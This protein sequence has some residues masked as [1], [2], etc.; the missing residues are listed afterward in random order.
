M[1]SKSATMTDDEVRQY[2]E[3]VAALVAACVQR[4][5]YYSLPDEAPPDA[6][7]TAREAGGHEHE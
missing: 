7:E 2:R 4:L 3:A 1:T 5:R 6:P